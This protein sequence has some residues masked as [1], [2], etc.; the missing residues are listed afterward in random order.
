MH[1]VAGKPFA[2]GLAIGVPLLDFVVVVDLPSRGIHR[3]HLSG[4]EASLLYA[5]SVVN[6]NDSC[7]ASQ[8]YQSIPGDL[9][10]GR[11]EAVAIKRGGGDS[12]ITERQCRRPVPRFDQAG[13]VLVEGTPCFIHVRHVFPCLGH[14]HHHAVEGVTPAVVEQFEGVV[15]AGGV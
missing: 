5:I 2:V 15:K 14:E 11:A 12:A 3:D 10:A 13:V 6:L 4:A 9:V 8:D 7:L 1:E